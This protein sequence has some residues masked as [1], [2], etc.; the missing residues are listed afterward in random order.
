MTITQK[1]KWKKEDGTEVPVVLLNEITARTPGYKVWGSEGVHDATMASLL[2]ATN[3]ANYANQQD[4]LRLAISLQT[5]READFWE[6]VNKHQS[7][8][9]ASA[10]YRYYVKAEKVPVLRK[11]IE[12]SMS[13]TTVRQYL[14]SRGYNEVEFFDRRPLPEGD[15]RLPRPSKETPERGRE[16]DRPVVL[17]KEKDGGYNACNQ[18]QFYCTGGKSSLNVEFETEMT[19]DK[20][21]AWNIDPGVAR[22][23]KFKRSK[24]DFFL[25]SI[26]REDGLVGK[27]KAEILR[28]IIAK[29]K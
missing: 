7:P 14:Q 21:Y 4:E 11:A 18:A 20:L 10:T 19:R 2:I 28:E 29:E 13:P 27:I 3:D 1:T 5:P 8:E 24:I 22:I 26:E 6:C 16:I 15:G 9:G 17:I 25:S 12:K 23:T